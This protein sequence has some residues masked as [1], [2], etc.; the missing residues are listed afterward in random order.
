MPRLLS[1]AEMGLAGLT[2][3]A[4]YHRPEM[5][6]VHVTEKYSEVTNGHYLVR[7]SACSIEDKD[8]PVVPG[9]GDGAAT[10]YLIPGEVLTKAAKDVSHKSSIPVLQTLHVG[11][12]GEKTVLTSTDLD[13]PQV[14]TFQTPDAK[15]PPCD[16]VIPEDSEERL[17][18][19]LSATYLKKLAA[20]A[21]KHGNERSTPIQFSVDPKAGSPVR[22]VFRGQDGEEILI[23]LM[24]TRY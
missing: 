5:E 13:S 1:R 10:E 24:P 15:F 23:V 2:V 6:H 17:K 20:F 16:K 19:A 22:M 14:R 9:M 3:K 18:F 7:V 11:T 8:F 21:E 4:D 12:T